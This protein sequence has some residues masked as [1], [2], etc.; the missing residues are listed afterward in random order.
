MNRIDQLFREK[1]EG[2]LSIYMTAGYPDLED[3]VEIISTLEESGVD[4]IELG[5]PFSDPLADGE[6]I[7][8]SSMAALKNGMTISKLF[9][10]IE[11]IRQ[12]VQI[13]LVLMGYLNPVLQFGFE[14]FIEK[15]VDTGID[16]LILP[17]LPLRI[18]ER[19]YMSMI[20]DSGLKFIMLITPQTDPGRIERIAG[21]SGGFL[22]MVADA[23]TTGSRKEISEEQ[24]AYFNRIRRMKLGIPLMI[25]F[26]ISDEK[27]FQTAC[28]YASGAII[29]SAFIRALGVNGDT[30]PERARKFVQSIR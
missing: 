23:S 20:S 4:M 5:M 17:D 7:Q 15:C 30:A 10:Q 1:Q 16:G 25:G 11:G 18:Y 28:K 27:T 2:V 13:P 3:T 26:G 29:G 21:N 12:N 6:V 8:Q 22:Y 24:V 9:E 14:R 19:D